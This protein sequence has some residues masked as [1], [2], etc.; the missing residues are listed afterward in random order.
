MSQTKTKTSLIRLQR[1]IE[2]EAKEF[3][4]WLNSTGELQDHFREL[5]NVTVAATKHEQQRKRPTDDLSPSDPYLLYEKKFNGLMRRIDRHPLPTRLQMNMWGF[6]ED[7]LP[8]FGEVAIRRMGRKR[9]DLQVRLDGFRF[10]AEQGAFADFC[11]CALPTCGK[12]FFSLRRKRRYCSDACQRVHYS[13]SPERKRKNRE[14]VL[15]FYHRLF[16]N[17]K[18]RRRQRSGSRPTQRVS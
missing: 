12:S 15:A 7:P 18:T 14:H 5:V 17:A 16:P 11:R 6:E 10:L 3:A 4:T 8:Q 2:N 13:Q 9:E 1:R